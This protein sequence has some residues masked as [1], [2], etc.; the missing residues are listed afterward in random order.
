MCGMHIV[1]LNVD[2][3]TLQVL[4]RTID[5]ILKNQLTTKQAKQDQCRGISA[6]VKIH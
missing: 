2:T 3:L 1:R 4:A 5:Q 6:R